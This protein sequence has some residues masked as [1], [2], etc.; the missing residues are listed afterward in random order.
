MALVPFPKGKSG[1]PGGRPKGDIELRRAARERTA[2]ALA[3]L[4]NVM[5][6]SKSPS[7]RVIAAEAILSR[8]W[9]KPVQPQAFTDM[10]GDD[11]PFPGELMTDLE[12]ARRIAFLLSEGLRSLPAQQLP[13]QLDEERNDG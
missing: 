4:V 7:A 8:G 9:G 11:R 6:T 5:R 13:E 2:E 3:T 10:G 1:N 12:K